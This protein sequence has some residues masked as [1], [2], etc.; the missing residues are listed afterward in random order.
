VR[1]PGGTLVPE[2]THTLVQHTSSYVSIRQHTSINLKSA[3]AA[4]VVLWR[5]RRRKRP[6]ACDTHRHDSLKELVYE[7]LKGLVYEALKLLVYEAF[8]C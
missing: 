3:C 1:S 4:R 2:A 5:G 7:L 6:R 8:S